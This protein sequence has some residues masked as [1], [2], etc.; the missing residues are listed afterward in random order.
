[1]RRWLATLAWTLLSFAWPAAAQ[2]FAAVV[3]GLRLEYPRDHGAHPE[4]RTEWWYVTG[5][6]DRPDGGP[7]GFQVTFFRVRTGLG[8]SSASAFAPRQLLFAHAALSDP[9]AGRLLHA[10]KAARAGMG[11]AGAEPGRGEVWIDEWS[12]RAERQDWRARVVAADFSF[13][14][15][16]AATQPPMANGRGGYS[17]KSPDPKHASYYYS[18]P[19]LRVTGELRH[20]DAEIAVRGH[21]WL[22]HEWSSEYLPAGAVG[23]DWAGIN[24]ADGGALMAFRMRDAAGASLWAGGSWRRPDGSLQVFEPDEVQFLPLRRWRSPRTGAAWP[25]ALQ[26]RAGPHDLTLEPLMDDQELDARASVGA[27]YWEGAVRARNRGAEAGRGYLELTG[28]A[29][30]LRMR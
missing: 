5:W 11:L 17:Q 7:L 19:Q 4:F 23:W 18:I 21:A 24:L 27:I 20:G 29:Q 2:E 10:E 6:L 1:V 25:V 26:L 30:R 16:L 3:P 12:L 15:R 22:D 8:E 13:D 9:Q 14:L 28:Y